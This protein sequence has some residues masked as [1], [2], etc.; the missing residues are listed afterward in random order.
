MGST[1]RYGY[2]VFCRQSL[3]GGN[4]G[5]LRKDS[6]LPTPDLYAALLWTRLM[7]RTVLRANVSAPNVRVFAHCLKGDDKVRPGFLGMLFGFS[8]NLVWSGCG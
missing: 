4:Y 8:R 2:D 3:I 6:A 1:A 7:G 5:L